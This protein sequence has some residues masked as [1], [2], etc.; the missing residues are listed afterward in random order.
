MSRKKSRNMGEKTEQK[1]FLQFSSQCSIRAV[2]F[3]K[4]ETC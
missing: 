2:H 1:K 4:E 3:N